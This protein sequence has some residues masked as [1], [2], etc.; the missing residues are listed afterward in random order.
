MVWHANIAQIR[1]CPNGLITPG[2][3]VLFVYD[4]GILGFCTD[5]ASWSFFL[6][7]H[8]SELGSFIAILAMELVVAQRMVHGLL[9]CDFV[10]SGFLCRCRLGTEME[11]YGGIVC[12]NWGDK[13][14]IGFGRFALEGE[15]WLQSGKGSCGG[16]LMSFAVAKKM[17]GF[18]VCKWMLMVVVFHGRGVVATEKMVTIHDEIGGAAMV[19]L[20]VFR[21]ERFGK[22]VIRVLE[23]LWRHMVELVV[24]GWSGEMVVDGDTR[25]E[26][27]N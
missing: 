7:I 5:C 20:R 24:T 16:V 15:D 19:D 11:E 13:P 8:D 1:I 17:V 23:G 14:A 25:K 4:S 27:E 18:S 26:K 6:Q 12:A 2:K 9:E 21:D 10:V 3:R 22:L